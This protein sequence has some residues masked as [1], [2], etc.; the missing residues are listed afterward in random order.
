MA[1]RPSDL[2]AIPLFERI[3]EDHLDEL[4]RAFQ[5][6][7]VPTGHVLFEAG[8][9]P[10]HMLLLVK[11]E[12]A[13]VDAGETRFRLSPISPIGELG[14]LTGL[15]RTT[16]AVTT[17]PSEVWRIGVAELQ[18]FFEAHGDVAY[19]FYNN[20]LN[21]VAGKIRRDAR[22]IEE[23]RANLI[24]TQKA[25]K[26]L[27]DL[28]LDSE[29]TPLSKVICSTLEDL[30]EK[31]RRSHYM[32]EPAHTLKSAVRLDSGALVPVVE[33]SDGWLR[34]AGLRDAAK[35]AH[36][37]GVLVLP[38]REIPVSGTI[39]AVDD[40]GALVKLDLLIDEYAAV[41]QDYLTRLQM[42]DFVV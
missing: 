14:A 18:D 28:V 36:W 3:T 21:V 26:R 38:A 4:M 42:L 22:R 23:V 13:L 31:N 29:E 5:R 1:V 39:D 35:G 33:L 41:L 20:L 15:R 34:L 16:T 2:H 17:Q 24:R 10:A 37:S 7:E 12:V 9:A 32:V 8:S 19:P 27:L 6:Q 11:G 25:M 40:Q 30:I